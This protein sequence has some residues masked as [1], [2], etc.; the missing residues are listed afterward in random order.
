MTAL[1]VEKTGNGLALAL[2]KEVA[3]QLSLVEGSDLLLIA[4]GNGELRLST[5]AAETERQIEIGKRVMEDYSA[6]F[7]ALAK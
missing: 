1:K 3:E 2:P 6:T 7:A 5:R 4:A